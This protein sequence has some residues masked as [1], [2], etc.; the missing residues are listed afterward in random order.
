ML[1]KTHITF[2]LSLASVGVFIIQPFIPIESTHLLIFY[3]AIAFGAIFPDIDEPHSKIGRMFIGVSHLMNAIFGH[4]GFTHS[5]PFIII[6]ILLLM[7]LCNFESVRTF[8][9]GFYENALVFLVSGFIL[10]NL[11]HIVGDMM[12]LSGV[13]IFLP[14]KSK[15]YFA[16]PKVLRFRT[17]GLADQVIAYI[18]G[19]LFLGINTLMNPT[20]TNHLQKML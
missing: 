4:R 2:A 12:T 6:L 5:L 13:P 20:I 7:V 8:I 3:F 9:N 11:L 1:A 19:A 10:G 16:L 17:S 18:C 15:K 14:F